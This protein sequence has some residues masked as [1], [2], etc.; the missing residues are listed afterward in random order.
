MSA[1]A[2]AELELFRQT[3]NCAAVLERMMGGWKLDVRQSTKR[4]EHQD[5]WG[6]HAATA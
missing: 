1:P 6:I 4:G 3:V 2:D 5:L